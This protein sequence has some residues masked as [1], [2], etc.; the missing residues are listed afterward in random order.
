V[1]PPTAARMP[2]YDIVSH[3]PRFLL[4][5]VS[6]CVLSKLRERRV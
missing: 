6:H 1:S 5:A 2:T 4:Q 3:N